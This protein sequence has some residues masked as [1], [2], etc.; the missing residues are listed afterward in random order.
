MLS[1]S[2]SL[3]VFVGFRFCGAKKGCVRLARV[4]LSPWNSNVSGAHTISDCR[5]TR[6]AL[7]CC[8][9]CSVIL[10]NLS[11][12]VCRF[13][14]LWCEEG[15]YASGTCLFVPLELGRVWST[16]NL[17][18]PEMRTSCSHILVN[19]SGR[20]RSFSLLSCESATPRCANPKGVMARFVLFCVLLFYFVL[21]CSSLSY[22]LVSVVCAV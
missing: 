4:C 21:F 20:V 2:T 22:F 9:V 5:L 6:N 16:R 13:S 15:V 8:S 14:P 7:E 1:S 19:L 17:G 12:G 10:V 18:K 3:G 11:G